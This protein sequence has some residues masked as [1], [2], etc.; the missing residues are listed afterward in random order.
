MHFLR[1]KLLVIFLFF[2]ILFLASWVS[3][4][5]D[6]VPTVPGSFGV[7]EGGLAPSSYGSVYDIQISGNIAYVAG[8]FDYAGPYT[9][10]AVLIGESGN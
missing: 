5:A 4:Q 8:N 10:H 3:V 9:G 7:V 1:V 2:S 6:L